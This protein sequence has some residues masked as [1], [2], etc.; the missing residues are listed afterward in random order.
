MPGIYKPLQEPLV[1]ETF[2]GIGEDGCCFQHT[3]GC[4]KRFLASKRP[5]G[6]S[7]RSAASVG[8]SQ[9]ARSTGSGSGRRHRRPNCRCFL[10]GRLHGRLH[11]CPALPSTHRS[12]I[13]LHRICWKLCLL[14]PL[15]IVTQQPTPHTHL[16]LPCG[17]L[18]QH[19]RRAPG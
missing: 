3:P 10:P 16:R 18:G 17:Q 19:S 12:L 4:P 15:V 8:R 14:D 9:R 2:L 7:Q 1:P 13:P 6:V 5:I 11:S